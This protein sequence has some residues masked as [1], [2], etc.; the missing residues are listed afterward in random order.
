MTHSNHTLIFM[1]IMSIAYG[2][3]LGLGDG[4]LSA[5]QIIMSW[6]VLA[7]IFFL[8]IILFKHLFFGD[9]R[10]GTGASSASSYVLK[11][12]PSRVMFLLF[13][14]AFIL[15][16]PHVLLYDYL[17][18]RWDIAVSSARILL[19]GAVTIT[20]LAVWIWLQPL[21]GHTALVLTHNGFSLYSSRE[22]PWKDVSEVEIKTRDA[23]Y[24]TYSLLF[25]LRPDSTAEPRKT[26]LG[27]ALQPPRMGISLEPVCWDPE[28][29]IQQLQK[30]VP[31]GPDTAAFPVLNLDVE[32][33]WESYTGD[34]P[35]QE[36]VITTTAP[37]TE[38]VSEAETVTKTEK[39]KKS[40]SNYMGS[41]FHLGNR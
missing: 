9:G 26:M 10:E 32:T 8:L 41:G 40:E 24:T 28:E 13:V 34:A 38:S 2:L 18:N 17:F 1:A 4:Y 21:I 7:G 29:L 20:L 31:S 23:K 37:K 12:S 27:R 15:S 6:P 33:L 16:L 11:V 5:W 39:P 35:A 3:L 36:P 30:F 14:L 22:I 25:Y 19:G